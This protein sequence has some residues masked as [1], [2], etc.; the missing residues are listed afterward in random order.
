MS[1]QQ[2]EDEAR[3]AEDWEVRQ[4]RNC[5][6]GLMLAAIIAVVGGCLLALVVNWII[7]VMR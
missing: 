6:Q 4:Q 1:E 5:N 2:A 3:I 7:E